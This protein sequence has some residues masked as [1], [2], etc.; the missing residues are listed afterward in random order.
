MFLECRAFCFFLLQN[1]S[2]SF[3]SLFVFCNIFNFHFYEFC[4]AFLN[5]FRTY[6][7]FTLHQISLLIFFFIFITGPLIVKEEKMSKSLGNSISVKE[8]L[9]K[10]SP[11]YLRMLCLSTHYGSSKSDLSHLFFL[12][13]ESTTSLLIIRALK[14]LAYFQ[15]Q[16]LLKIKYFWRVEK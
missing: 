10:N 15:T 3:S 11:N 2:K 13:P 5:F 14:I 1:T 8:Y 16:T 6:F 9:K 12:V 4:V 7:M